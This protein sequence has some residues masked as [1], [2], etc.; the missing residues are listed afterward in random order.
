M[1][2]LLNN[3]LD[4]AQLNEKEKL[5]FKKSF[6]KL[7]IAKVIK[8]VSEFDITDAE[9]LLMTFD[10]SESDFKAVEELLKEI[11]SNQEAKEKID[12]AVKEVSD[13]LVKNIAE[14]ATKEQKQQI[15][16]FVNA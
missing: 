1:D 11:S 8:S 16:S 15:L 6:Y 12:Q 3:I 7:L 13:N 14:N 9:R 10:K 5:D 4:I 2:D